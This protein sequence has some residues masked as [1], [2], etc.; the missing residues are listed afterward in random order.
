[1][2]A[3]PLYSGFEDVKR[4]IAEAKGQGMAVNLDFHYS[5][6]WA[7]PSHQDIPAA[8]MEI[9]DYGGAERFRLQLYVRNSV[10]T[11]R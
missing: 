6:I 8:W 3:K 2:L 4:S 1:M 5:D 9:T 7:D 10:K 11:G